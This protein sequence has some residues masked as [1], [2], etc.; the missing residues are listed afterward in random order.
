MTNKPINICNIILSTWFVR[1]RYYQEQTKTF[2]LGFVF[3][4]VLAHEQ[5]ISAAT[6][7]V[8]YVPLGLLD[9]STCG[10]SASG[11]KYCGG[12]MMSALQMR[13][14]GMGGN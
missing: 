10:G 8:W 9:M 13:R 11:A 6:Y 3:V 1:H 2:V 7:K 5:A 12:S 14:K 4:F